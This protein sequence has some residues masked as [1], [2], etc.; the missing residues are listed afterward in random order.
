MFNKLFTILLL[1]SFLFFSTANT[2]QLYR[3]SSIQ[4]L[5]N[6]IS[7]IFVDTTKSEYTL[8]MLCISA[9]N[10]DE[11]G[12]DGVA[13]LLSKIVCRRLNQ[14]AENMHYGCE[15]NSYVG[16]DQSLYYFYGKLENL[17]GFI[18]NLGTVY[19]N[20]EFSEEDMNICKQ[21]ISQTITSE[22][23][24]D[25]LVA[26]KEAMK[27]MYW[28]SKYGASLTGNMEDISEISSAD[29]KEFRDKFY[30]NSRVL[31]I[32]AGN[33][34]KKV[35]TDLINK[36]FIKKDI[37]EDKITRLQEPSHHDSVTRLTKYSSQVNVPII[38]ICWEIPNYRNNRNEA[39][40]TEIFIN[41]LDTILQSTIIEE[42]TNVASMEFS[43]SFWNYDYGTF[44]MTITAND[45][46]KVEELITSIL[47]EI[48]CIASDG[49]S[50]KQA[51]TAKEK[52]YKTSSLVDRNMIDAIGIISM[53]ISSGNSL[54]FLKTYDESIKKCNLEIINSQ[55][56]EIFNKYP[57]VINVIY[58]E[59]KLHGTITK[60][61][62]EPA[63]T[64]AVTIPMVS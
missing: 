3:E 13:N 31:L 16:H 15:S 33:V 42:Q 18:K 47:T 37:I 14:N 5:E 41:A 32:V 11:I 27:C 58:P 46:S 54:D 10:T 59:K 61:N 2:S 1:C 48:R 39:L 50:Q 28:H 29:I 4:Q 52:L 43:Y 53:K 34:D 62:L 57:R 38:E 20:L 26:S 56:K 63:E 64:K 25:R 8:V 21:E 36:Y 7:V 6:G 49:I 55:A 35:S 30:K 40:A 51:N 12:R 45:D 60:K 9:G 24:I 19:S 22:N 23:Q 17:E 44:R